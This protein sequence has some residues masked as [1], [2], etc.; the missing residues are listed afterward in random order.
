MWLPP[1]FEGHEIAV[2]WAD[3]PE[4]AAGILREYLRAPDFEASEFT[5]ERAIDLFG[6]ETIGAQWKTYLG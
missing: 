1:L 3:H 2:E 6:N 4:H 5:R